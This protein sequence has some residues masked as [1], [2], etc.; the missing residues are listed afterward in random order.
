VV[1][2]PGVLDAEVVDAE[3][4]D[5][6]AVAVAGAA[7][8][9]GAPVGFSAGAAPPQPVSATAITAVTAVT[10]PDRRCVDNDI[11]RS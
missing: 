7:L 6:E 1:V 4:V 3:A 10:I 8:D 2:G 5:A 11:C 9:A